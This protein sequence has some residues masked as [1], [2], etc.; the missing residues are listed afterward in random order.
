MTQLALK[1]KNIILLTVQAIILH[2]KP[3]FDLFFSRQDILDKTYFL[4]IN[5]SV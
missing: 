2:R 5:K 4:K 1:L 3:Y